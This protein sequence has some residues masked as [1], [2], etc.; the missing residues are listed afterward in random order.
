MYYER[1]LT[2]KV[3]IIIVCLIF[4]G[5]CNQN[6]GSFH[7]NLEHS[8]G[9]QKLVSIEKY[10]QDDPSIDFRNSTD[11]SKGNKTT[12]QQ[13]SAHKNNNKK[14]EE[15][16]EPETKNE[17]QITYGD[18]EHNDSTIPFKVL[19][20]RYDQTRDKDTSGNITKGQNGIKR[21]EVRKVYVNNKYSHTETVKDT[22]ILKEPIHE[23]K[24]IGT[25]EKPPEP[26]KKPNP[27]KEVVPKPKGKMVI[28]GETWYL[29][30]SFDNADA[31]IANIN[32]IQDEHFR[33]WEGGSMCWSEDLYYSLGK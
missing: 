2:M 30:K 5:S 12:N 9:N 31:C 25:K 16:S 26:E 15:Q 13:S 23:Q 21:K 4:L 33:D 27:P 7:D 32:K 24:W 20:T 22:Y 8:S 3:N 10:Q 6:I 11:N 18:I 19:D 29:Y 14:D 17:D 1:V 28:D